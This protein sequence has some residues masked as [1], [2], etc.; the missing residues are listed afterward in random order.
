MNSLFQLFISIQCQNRYKFIC[1]KFGQ[2]NHLIHHCL[3][4]QPL[5]VATKN[6]STLKHCCSKT[7]YNW[8][9]MSNNDSP[10]KFLFI[11]H[12]TIGCKLYKT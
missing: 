10:V 9:H 6:D 1:G 12:A 3:Q 4:W 2:R 5:V 11:Y 7:V 8:L